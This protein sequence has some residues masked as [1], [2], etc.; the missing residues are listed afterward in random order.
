VRK[1]TGIINCNPIAVP[2][3]HIKEWNNS[4]KLGILIIVAFIVTFFTGF[5]NLEDTRPRYTCPPTRLTGSNSQR[6]FDQF[7]ARYLQLV[8]MTVTGSIVDEVGTCL[9]GPNGCSL[10]NLVPYDSEL[11]RLGDDWPAVGHTMVGHVRL[12]NIYDALSSVI[13]DNIPGDFVELGVW[14]GGSAIYAKAVLY[15]FGAEDRAVH[16]FD[17]FEVI[18]SYGG[19][20]SSYLSVSQKEVE[21]NFKKYGLDHNVVFHK[22]LFKDS[23]PVFR[24]ESNGN[25]IAVLRIDGNFYDS[26]QDALYYLYELVPV[27]GYVI[28]DDAFSHPHVMKCWKDFK[29]E[30]GLPEELTAI[31]NNA[32]WFRKSVEI[33]VDWKFFREPQD[34]NKAGE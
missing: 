5:F 22:G 1:L 27:G 15:A 23:V 8:E 25:A 26:Y 34:A 13:D 9:T 12:H 31:D 33:K 21:H 14:R 32:A 6:N 29:S 16:V 10:Q 2:M 4:A 19:P 18:P 17:A 3:L 7:R 30:Q 20:L 11:R 28:F 24:K